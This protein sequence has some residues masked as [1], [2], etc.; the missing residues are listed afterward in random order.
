MRQFGRGGTSNSTVF[1]HIYAGKS[2]PFFY[3]RWQNSYATFAT[4]VRNYFYRGYKYVASF[5]LTAFYNSID[6]HVLKVFLQQS[7]VDPDTTS[8]LLRNLKHWTEATWSA[9]RGRPIYHE[10][11]IPQGPAAS[12]MLSEVVLQHLDAIGDR[13]SK[14]IC[15][16]RYV[17]DIKLMAK[18]E[19]ALRRKL[20]ALDIAAK[21]IGLFPQSS[22]IAIREIASPEEEIRSVSIPFEPAVATSATQKD[23]QQRV[24]ELANRGNPKNV[25]RFKY[26]LP[27]LKP[28]HVTN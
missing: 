22:K 6:H 28:T 2:S 11:G 26:V 21:E 14:D 24:K 13:K 15:Y 23:V 16:L 4:A 3:I 5:D 10:H 12:G 1:F 18:D 8:F 19:K 17:D 9:G 27:L 25:T 7:G 20:V